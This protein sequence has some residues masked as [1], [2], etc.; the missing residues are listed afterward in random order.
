MHILNVRI[1]T[2]LRIVFLF[3]Y[4]TL[5]KLLGEFY[6]KILLYIFTAVRREFFFCET[7]L[8]HMIQ[9]NKKKITF[10]KYLLIIMAPVDL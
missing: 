5:N 2:K 8:M 4:I 3:I 6:W 1:Y 9:I 10:Y 7:R